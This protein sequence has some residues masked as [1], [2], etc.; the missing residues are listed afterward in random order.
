MV[1]SSTIFLC[2]FLPVVLLLY[3]AAPGIHLKNAVLLLSSLF[4]YAWGEPKYIILMTVS[5]LGNYL[6]GLGIHARRSK[7]KK[8]RA[9]LVFSVLFNLGTLFYFKYFTFAAGV[10]S[11]VLSKEIEVGNIALPIGISFY[12]FQGM[13][14]V[15]DVYRQDMS[16]PDGVMVQKNPAKLGLYI[17]MFPQLIAG[18]IIR[19]SDIRSYLSERRSTFAK[20]SEGAEIF[21]RGLAKKV[22]FANILGNVATQ[23]METNAKMISAP[24]AWLGAFC[25]SLQIFYD[26]CGYSEMAIGLGKM[27]GFEFMKNFNF[28]YISRSVTEFWRRWHI[29]LSQWFRD[30]L[31][32]PLGGNR[33][34][35]VYF[36]LFIVFLAT[37][38]WHGAD[39]GFILWGMWHGAFMLIERVLKKRGISPRLPK[40]VSGG[41]GWLYTMFVVM[42]GW[43]LFR[44]VDVP[45]TVAYLKVMFGISHADFVRYG[46]RWYL[47]DRTLTVLVFATLFCFPWREVL[48]ARFPAARRFSEDTRVVIVRRV[49]LL[50]L[51]VLCFLLITNSTYN[52]FIYFRF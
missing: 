47:N 16:S 28:P 30:Y 39:W 22:I 43:V 24:Q 27:F 52:P 8:A 29:S 9:L 34:G 33:K 6:F 5:I 18:P 44:I 12:T 4:F 17:S 41:L 50:L 36:H 11:S 21:I 32:I 48:F 38:I 14:Y 26:F 25:Y 3:Y 7:E 2:V 49:C 45:D 23:I 51:L 10:L 20:F 13:S 1:F 31:Y 35:N 40:P 15:I 42:L 19:Y 46:I 37:G